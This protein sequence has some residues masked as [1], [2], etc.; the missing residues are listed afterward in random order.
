MSKKGWSFSHTGCITGLSFPSSFTLSSKLLR[1]QG[2][3][4][5]CQLLLKSAL[6]FQRDCEGQEW[7]AETGRCG[8]GWNQKEVTGSKSGRLR[9]FKIINS[10]LCSFD[11]KIIHSVSLKNKSIFLSFQF[12][13]LEIK[14][15]LLIYLSE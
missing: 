6:S 4:P 3:S 12:Q 1:I 2:I 10:C 9:A 7:A 13:V 8:T 5:S 11:C 14:Q 15:F